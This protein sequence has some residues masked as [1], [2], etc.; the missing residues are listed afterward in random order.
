[1]RRELFT[2][3]VFWTRLVAIV[4][5]ASVG[6]ALAHLTW[7]LVGWDDGRDRIATPDA[8]APPGGG[9][10]GLASILALNPFGGDGGFDSL[11]ASSLGLVL[12]GVIYSSDPSLSSALI[13]SGGG[14]GQIFGV[15][16]TVVGSAAIDAIEMDRVILNVGGR[17]ESLA[18]PAL[19]V[20]AG[21]PVSTGVTP[22]VQSGPAVAVPPPPAPGAEPPASGAGP[23]A[24]PAPSGQSGAANAAAAL[25][26]A[27]L[28]ATSEGY[29]V[30]PE[31]SAQMRRAGLQAG[32]LIRSLNGRP[33]GDV[34]SDQQLIERA[35]AAGS[36]RVEVVRGGRSLTLT[37]PLR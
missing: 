1:M 6:L 21:A 7:R 27:G 12:K 2:S 37:F 23:A 3:P 15:G 20:A 25:S 26:G 22:P 29:R 35:V 24:R 17:R 10:G 14:P 4:V 28:A 18:F 31:P 13:S 11:P 33:V 5:V 36:A 8:L 34:A 32:D 30:G 9:S 16:Q 19:P